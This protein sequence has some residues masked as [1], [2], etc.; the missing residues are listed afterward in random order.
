MPTAADTH[1]ALQ[2]CPASQPISADMRMPPRFNL[3]AAV[4]VI[5]LSA[6]AAFAD[7]SEVPPPDPGTTCEVPPDDVVVDEGEG[8][9]VDEGEGDVVDEG[10]GDVVDEGEGDAVDEGEGDVVDE[11]EGDV[12]DEGEGDVVDE[13]VDEEPAEDGVEDG[14]V[15]PVVEDRQAA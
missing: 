15:E 6:G 5:A 14:A 4:L 10:E 8:D 2:D 9:A 7:G 1:R 13:C 12:V 3:L 11:G